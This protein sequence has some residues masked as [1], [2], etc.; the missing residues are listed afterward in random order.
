MR[1]NSARQPNCIRAAVVCGDET[2]KSFKASPFYVHICYRKWRILIFRPDFAQTGS[3]VSSLERCV[4]GQMVGRSI[5]TLLAHCTWRKWMLATVAQHIPNIYIC[6]PDKQRVTAP[7]CIVHICFVVNALIRCF[8]IF[9]LI[10]HRH[11]EEIYFMSVFMRNILFKQP[12][13]SSPC[14]CVDRRMLS[15]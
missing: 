5:C 11:K 13:E 4:L 7:S 15:E 6:W 14:V 12:G 8:N 2:L 10:P 1:E 3:P 9:R